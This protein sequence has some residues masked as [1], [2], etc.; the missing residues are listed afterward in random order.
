M[1]AFTTYNVISLKE[2]NNIIFLKTIVI[3]NIFTVKSLAIVL[4]CC[5]IHTIL[6]NAK[7]WYLE[8]IL[9]TKKTHM[10]LKKEG[11]ND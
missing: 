5:N 9:Q 8:F 10:G 3:C 1:M 6:Y 7:A 4:R 11:K 2:N